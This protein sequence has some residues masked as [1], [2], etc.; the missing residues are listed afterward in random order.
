[1]TDRSPPTKLW[2]LEVKHARLLH[3]LFASALIAAPLPALAQDAPAA[4]AAPPAVPAAPMADQ[5]TPA[6]AAPVAEKETPAAPAPESNPAPE[7]GAAPM[8]SQEASAEQEGGGATQPFQVNVGDVQISGD[9]FEMDPTT[10]LIT[11]SGNPRAVRGDEEI[12]A[13]RMIINP[14]TLQF[15]AEGDVIIRQSGREVRSTRATYSFEQKAGQAESA[16]S[17]IKNYFVDADQILIK[18]GPVYE[19]RRATFST[20][21]REHKHWEVY[22]RILDVIPGEELV[23]H[24]AGLDLLG[25]RLI[26]IPRLR[27]SLREGDDDDNA[28]RLLPQVGYNRRTG[29][30]VRDDFT[31]RNRGPVFIDAEAQIN[32]QQEP[33]GGFLFGTPGRLKF[34]GALYYRDVS[35]NQRSQNMQVSR[36]PEVGAVW[37]SYQEARPGRFLNDRIQ[38]LNYPRAL[39]V[40]T[41]WIFNAQ[42]TVGFFRQHSGDRNLGPDSRSKNGGRF[43]VLGQAILPLV[44]LGP[45][46]LND[47]RLLARNSTYD[48]GDN[49]TTY[50]FGIGKRVRTGHWTF[51][52][53][54]FQQFTAGSTPFFF[55]DIELR[56]EVRPSIEYRTRGFEFAYQVR[57]NAR[58]GEIFDQYFEISKLFHCIKPT[59]GYSVRRSEIFL[60][61]RIP[62]LSGRAPTNPTESRTRESGDQF[63]LAPPLE[64]QP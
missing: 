50:G 24:N 28:L 61:I 39:D 5:D 58:N 12:R 14:R 56:Q 18:P 10:G 54:Y 1:M 55:D 6:P 35:P 40:S 32:T 52:A 33:Q 51:R 17:L 48:T 38:S 13:T 45:V 9:Q 8:S 20:C 43:S 15:T 26:T 37:S 62:G 59:I 44:K 23:A 11:V 36:L 25:H 21:D 29:F 27:K 7:P 64:T 30:Y 47:L 49:F 41:N 46:E 57:I 4:P 31:I 16:R 19:A 42:A 53:D 34:V 22:G 60:E 3:P 2:E 63:R